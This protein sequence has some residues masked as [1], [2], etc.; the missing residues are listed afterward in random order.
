MTSLHH[1]LGGLADN[2]SRSTKAVRVTLASAEYE[3]IKNFLLNRHF[4]FVWPRVSTRILGA[5]V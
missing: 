4:S 2:F 1:F 5:Q 3:D